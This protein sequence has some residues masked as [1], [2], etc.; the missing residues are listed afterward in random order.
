[1]E[2]EIG[3]LDLRYAGVRARQ[4]RREGQVQGSLEAAGQQVPIVVVREGERYVVVDG[5]KRVTA[6]RRL[7][8]DT[9]EATDWG[10][11]EGEALVLLDVLRRQG[12][13]SALEDAW[14]VEAVVASSGKSPEA[15]AESLGRSRGWLASRTEL[16]TLL[17]PEIQERV[18]R[19]QI[20]PRV[21]SGPLAALALTNRR[22][23]G[24]LAEAI[25]GKKVTRREAKELAKAYLQSEEPVRERLLKDPMLFLKARR[26]DE[27]PAEVLRL[28]RALLRAAERL[29]EAVTASGEGLSGKA[30]QQVDK[31]LGIV[32]FVSDVPVQVPGGNDDRPEQEGCDP[33]ACQPEIRDTQDR[34][35]PEGLP[36]GREEGDCLP[37][38][39]GATRG[40]ALGPEPARRD[41]LRADRAMRRQPREGPRGADH[42]GGAGVVLDADRLRPP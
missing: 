17:S 12:R 30:R 9:V 37:A 19:G 11:S 31:M 23:S 39:T 20:D 7:H 38:G 28:A 18:R 29:K 42:Q 36:H 26:Q 8:Q 35:A 13:P 3:Q 21:A 1:M 6:A 10:L 40:E 32:A 27:G 5:F 14:L 2:I 15:V 24:R 16:R 34:Q 4:K 22:A 33:A 41:D 25:A